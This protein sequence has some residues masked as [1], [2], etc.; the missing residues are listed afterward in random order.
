MLLRFYVIT[1]GIIRNKEINMLTGMLFILSSRQ[2]VFKS[3][4]EGD[5]FKNEEL[6]ERVENI[7][8]YEEAILVV[9]E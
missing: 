3:L 7:R 2:R 4:A 6:I 8:N 1:Y 5:I 9:K